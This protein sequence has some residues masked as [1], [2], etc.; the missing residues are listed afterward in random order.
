MKK[1]L[2]IFTITICALSALAQVDRNTGTLSLPN[3]TD[4]AAVIIKDN[5]AKV[6][7]GSQVDSF[8]IDNSASSLL[9]KDSLDS[10]K[11]Y[12]LL[13]I[14][15]E[16]LGI[17]LKDQ[18]GANPISKLLDI[19]SKMNEQK[20]VI[21]AVGADSTPPVEQTE[22]EGAQPA[23]VVENSSSNAWLIPGL[24]GLAALAIGFFIGKSM[25]KPAPVQELKAPEPLEEPIA[26]GIAKVS[27]T[28]NKKVEALT[29]E[30]E[31]LQEK[32]RLTAEKS[33]QLI[34]GD[35]LYYGAVFERI[36]LPL[37]TALDN[38]DEAEV[39]KYLNLSMVHLS[40]VTRLKMRK[41]QNYDDA[42]IQLILGNANLTQ[43]FPAI[44]AQTPI[45]KIPANLR[46]LIQ[47][48]QKSGVKGLGDTV[49]KGYKIKNLI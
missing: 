12:A 31:A 45:D 11:I 2:L 49:I 8:L 22:E 39:I 18:A 35:Q 7:K 26:E 38:G 28:S 43:D 13:G 14:T 17:A 15:A 44:D 32:N 41:K 16:Q 1:A 47:I 5:I 48:L 42:N 34:D 20:L 10:Q 46:V 23:T 25:Q 24:I 37:Q 3:F 27:K 36:I 30:I 21:Q 19:A 29:K 6:Q 4:K 9:L 33:Q 40:S